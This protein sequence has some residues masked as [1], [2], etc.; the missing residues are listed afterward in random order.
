MPSKELRD[1]WRT[2]GAMLEIPTTMP[3]GSLGAP[4]TYGAARRVD[5][6]ERREANGCGALRR[7]V[8][9]DRSIAGV[10]LADVALKNGRIGMTRH[11][12]SALEA[13]I[14]KTTF[15]PGLGS[16]AAVGHSRTRRSCPLLGRRRLA[17]QRQRCLRHMLRR[18]R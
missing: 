7:S 16:R 5:G 8:I 6:T 13:M 12:P 3:A 1:A 14:V 4:A 15:E 10:V 9:L 18:I 11:L 2:R 17:K